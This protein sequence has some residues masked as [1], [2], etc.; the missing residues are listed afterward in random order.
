[1][2]SGRSGLLGFLNRFQQPSCSLFCIPLPFWHPFLFAGTSRV[3]DGCRTPGR[4]RAY[5]G[6]CSCGSNISCWGRAVPFDPFL[7]VPLCSFPHI[8]EQPSTLTESFMKWSRKLKDS[9]K[10]WFCLFGSLKVCT[11][12]NSLSFP[13][14]TQGHTARAHLL[15]EI[16]DACVINLACRQ[17]APARKV[18]AFLLHVE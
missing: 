7:Q 12:K 8:P 16:H 15:G 18:W 9:E 14:Q 11:H 1:M 10:C 3:G 17:S 5:W 4:R 2:F 6:F 13:I